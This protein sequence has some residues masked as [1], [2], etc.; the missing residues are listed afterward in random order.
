MRIALATLVVFALASASGCGGSD[1]EPMPPP[2]TPVQPF[3]PE[4]AREAYRRFS[5]ENDPGAICALSTP[6]WQRSLERHYGLESGHCEDA[7]AQY[8]SENPPDSPGRMTV[9]ERRDLAIKPELDRSTRSAGFVDEFGN[10]MAFKH[11]D[12]H[13]LFAG[14]ISR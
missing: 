12:G 1:D 7:M 9:E 5:T 14:I 4:A 3:T 10:G 13:W 11:V 2:P 8:L 6:D